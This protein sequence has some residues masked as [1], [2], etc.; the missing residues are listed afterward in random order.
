[1]AE[2]LNLFSHSYAYIEWQSYRIA[3]IAISLES[4]E[5]V[6]S[7]HWAINQ[8]VMRF[9]DDIDCILSSKVPTKWLSFRYTKKDR[10]WADK[11]ITLNFFITNI[12]KKSLYRLNDHVSSSPFICRPATHLKRFR[13]SCFNYCI[14]R[15]VQLIGFGRI[16]INPLPMM[17]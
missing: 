1:M 5:S 13:L 4:I 10:V 3:Q 14:L 9:D 12:K 15:T 7:A 11:K 2:R 8:R 16:L 17:T 6:G